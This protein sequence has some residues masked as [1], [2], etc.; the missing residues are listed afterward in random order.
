MPVI[1]SSRWYVKV[2]V[3]VRPPYR[4]PCAQNLRD[5]QG[6]YLWSSVK[7][8]RLHSTGIHTPF[9]HM[10]RRL[11]QGDT[12]PEASF[13]YV[14]Y[15]PSLDSLEACGIVQ[16][17][18]TNA[19]KG[20]KVVLFGVPGAFTPACHQRHLPPYIERYDELKTKGVDIVACVSTNDAFVQSAWGR[21]NK[22]GDKVIM[23]SDGNANWSIK[24][25]LTV[26]RSQDGMGLR[27]TRFAAVI[28]DLKVTFLGLDE[29]KGQVTVSGV[30][31]VLSVL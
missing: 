5:S 8:W 1:L 2:C 6:S 21:A 11:Q 18:S 3:K 17:Y 20:K 15:D 23:L 25:G 10:A 7:P 19:W 24:T 9:L 4:M 22:A 29:A 26:D 16:R 12:I 13:N 14:P 27:T 30:E 28:E 31:H